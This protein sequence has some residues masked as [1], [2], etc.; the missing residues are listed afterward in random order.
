MLNVALCLQ[1][2]QI[3]LTAMNQLVKVIKGQNN[4]STA[5]YEILRSTWNL[6]MEVKQS[7]VLANFKPVRYTLK[8]FVPSAEY[9]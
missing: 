8:G 2:I 5:P 3:K 9:N 1:R 4:F 7:E 6:L